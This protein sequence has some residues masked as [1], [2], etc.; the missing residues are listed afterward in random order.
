MDFSQSIFL[1]M[2]GQAL[3]EKHNSAQSEQKLEGISRICCQKGY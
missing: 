2:H 1:K 3:L